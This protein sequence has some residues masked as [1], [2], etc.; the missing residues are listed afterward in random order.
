MRP[1][2]VLVYPLHDF[3]MGR[4][5]KAKT[6]GWFLRL[7]QRDSSAA[8]P[9]DGGGIHRMSMLLDMWKVH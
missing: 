6:S 4:H 7:V 1:K 2:F 9:G 8:T 3:V 5:I